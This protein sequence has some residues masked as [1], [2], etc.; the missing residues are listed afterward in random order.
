[1]NSWNSWNSNSKEPN[2][3][4]WVGVYQPIYHRFWI[5]IQNPNVCSGPERCIPSPLVL[6][7]GEP[8]LAVDTRIRHSTTGIGIS[9][10]ERFSPA[11]PSASLT[12]HAEPVL[13]N[14]FKL[15]NSMVGLALQ[16]RSSQ[17]AQ[18]TC[19]VQVR[20]ANLSERTYPERSLQSDLTHWSNKAV[21]WS[22]VRI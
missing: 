20:Y 13:R 10:C 5:H 14:L 7:Q 12:L 16:P 6:N 8:R 3:I 4:Y 9:T 2:R 15:G 18:I 17:T 11:T 1:M 22:N 19:Q 21:W